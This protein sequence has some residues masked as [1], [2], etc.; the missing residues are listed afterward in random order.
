MSTL[1]QP[2]VAGLF[3]P[4]EAGALQKQ[5]A[6]FFS[7]CDASKAR[8]A[9]ALIS[10]HAGYVYSGQTAASAFSRVKIPSRAFI[11]SPN[12][13]GDGVPLAINSTG[14]WRTPLGDVPIDSELARSFMHH[15]PWA[16]EDE[17]A[18]REEHSLEVQLPFLQCLRED[19]RF[20]PLTLQHLR[21]EDCEAI[22]LALAQTV[23]ESGEEVLLIASSDMNHYESHERTLQKDQYAIEPILKMD[24]R[25]LYEQVHRHDVSM[26]GI[27]PAT[28]CLVAARA[29][30]AS[31]AELVEHTTSGPV[32]GDYERVVGYASFIIS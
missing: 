26:C 30:G 9:I 13:T 25:A 20:V 11:L 4:A 18:H 31:R 19:F 1:R 15:C 27:I 6:S 32:S 14:A 10:P 16:Q 2:A 21:Y 29:L 23:R 8:R 28:V 12:H 17:E 3:Y 24:P 5:I 22:G 7:R